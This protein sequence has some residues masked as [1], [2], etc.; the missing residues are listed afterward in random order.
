MTAALV[1]LVSLVLL[2]ACQATPVRVDDTASAPAVPAEVTTPAPATADTPT[3]PPP[4]SATDGT[5]AV[6]SPPTGA[7]APS[8]GLP[9]WPLA[10][11]ERLRQMPP[12]QII[13]E[14]ADLGE[15]GSSAR[16]QM[17]L[18]LALMHAPP[19]QDTVRTLGLLQRVISHPG[20]E[21]VALKPL[22][23][24]LATRLATQ[25]KLEESNER[26]NLQWRDAQRRIELLN[27]QLD[28]MRAIERSLSPRPAATPS[29]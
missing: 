17:Q 29:R 7:V 13:A 22:A 11:A 20:D 23:R 3:S 21:A 10:Y 19:P 16:L 14:I 24:L 8:P 18:A 12:A 15:P 4:P 5:S 26:L 2:A 28:A 27:D 9:G 6:P 1:S 25:R